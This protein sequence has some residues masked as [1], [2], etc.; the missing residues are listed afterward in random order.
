MTQGH[1]PRDAIY[2]PGYTEA[3]LHRL[4]DQAQ[5]V[6]SATRTL[7]LEAGI[8][9]GM[10][11][12]DVG[13]GP[14][15]VSLL[16]AERVGPTGEVVGLD[17]SDRILELARAR[18]EASGTTQVRFVQTDLREYSVDSLFDAVVGR[19]VLM[20]LADP[21]G[22][23]RHVAQYVRPGGIVAF[24]DSQFEHTPMASARVPLWEQ[25]CAWIVAL[26]RR[27]GIETNMGVRLRQTFLDAGLPAPHVH[28]DVTLAC[29]GD[30]VAA[31]VVTNTLRSALPML[32]HFGI[33]TTAEVDV[34]TFGQRYAAELATSG[35]VHT[36]VPMVSAWTRKLAA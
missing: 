33:A 31:R 17:T 20:Y 10:R 29:P 13:C 14:G 34:D 3:E 32:E 11:V 12:L 24:Q 36:L 26:S 1:T 4:T 7:L 19:F 21:A 30:E 16:A 28:M 18:A 25:W 8:G 2:A 5:L 23:V 15:D 6:A 22:V 35:A 27:S 9:P